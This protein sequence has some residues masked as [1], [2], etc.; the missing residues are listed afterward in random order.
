MLL[1]E[2]LWKKMQDNE[3]VDFDW[4]KQGNETLNQRLVLEEYLMQTAWAE[5]FFCFSPDKKGGKLI[6]N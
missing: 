6:L 1:T 2:L 5:E 4:W 3:I